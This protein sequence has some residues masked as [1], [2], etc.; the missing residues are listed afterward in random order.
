MRRAPGDRRRG[1]S[2]GHCG[3]AAPSVP[4]TRFAA[5]SEAHRLHEAT[6]KAIGTVIE[7]VT[8]LRDSVKR[9]AGDREQVLIDRHS[10]PLEASAANHERRIAA[11]EHRE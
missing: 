7:G 11:I 6:T 2:P 1:S 10:A 4:G 3:R 5:W 8:M 9:R